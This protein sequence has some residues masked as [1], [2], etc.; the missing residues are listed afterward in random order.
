MGYYSIDEGYKKQ[1][2][3][4][5]Y[6]FTFLILPISLLA[7]STYDYAG[8]TKENSRA[9]IPLKADVAAQPAKTKVKLL[10][11]LPWPEYGQA[12][13]GVVDDG[14]LAES[15][16]TAQP[17]P[18]ASLAKVI[19][20][21]AVLE[22]KPLSEG[23]QGPL[24]T[25]TKQ[26]EKL[27]QQYIAKNGSVLPVKA[28]EQISQYQAMQAMLMIS[29]NNISDTLAIWAFGSVENYNVYANNM[30][31]ERGFKETVVADASGFSPE[32]KGTASEMVQLG[33]LYVKNPLL[34]GIAM[35]KQAVMPFAGMI[36]NY[37]STVN[38]SGLLGIKIGYTDEAGRTFLAADIN[39]DL[40]EAAVVAVF[41]AD[42]LG[43]AMHDAKILLD[44]GKSSTKTRF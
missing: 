14:V 25:I 4:K 39:K 6:L 10:K 43:T 27:Y 3:H 17:V 5:F 29:A 37:N 40:D 32:T 21:L 28:G 2:G 23:E 7:L 22:K 34:Q 35:Q 24:I 16:E 41:G 38:E 9:N 11:P 44:S 20:A 12:A 36:S 30:L 15:D 33:I 42:H 31:K 1:R 19:T 26:D 13:Y 8:S 18:V